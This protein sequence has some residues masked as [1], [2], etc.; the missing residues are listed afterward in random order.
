MLDKYKIA[1]EK[2]K[3]ER[4]SYSW[5]A[6]GLFWLNFSLSDVDAFDITYF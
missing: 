6:L 5:P 1:H 4:N 2:K 3:K